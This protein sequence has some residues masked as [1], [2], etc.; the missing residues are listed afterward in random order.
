MNAE[1]R[2]RHQQREQFRMHAY[3]GNSEAFRQSAL[4]VRETDPLKHVTIDNLELNAFLIECDFPA[5]EGKIQSM[6][7]RYALDERF[8]FVN[9]FSDICL[10]QNYFAKGQLRDA[11][12]IANNVI[13]NKAFI[14]D[15]DSA[16][17]LAMYRLLA[18]AYWISGRNSEIDQI[19]NMAGELESNSIHCTYIL[20]AIDA[21]YFCATGEIYKALDMAERN[22]AISSQHSFS[23]IYGPT[24][25]QLVAAEC[26]LH[27]NQNRKAENLLKPV[28]DWSMANNHLAWIVHSRS[29]EVTSLISSKQFKSGLS[30]LREMREILMTLKYKNNLG[31]LADLSEFE[32]R[33]ALEDLD[34]A[35]ILKDRLPKE[36]LGESLVARLG[37]AKGDDLTELLNVLPERNQ[38]DRIEK[39][40]I[41]AALFV[42]RNSLCIEYLQEAINISE[43]TGMRSL[44]FRDEKLASKIIAGANL[45]PTQFLEFLVAEL[46]EYLAKDEVLSSGGI[47]EPLTKR[48]LEVLRSMATGAKIREIGF[49]LHISMNT[50]KTHTRHIY[51]KL[52]ARGRQDAIQIARDHFLI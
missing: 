24:D 50:L 5:V 30:I 29:L 48:E 25:M 8:E 22:I 26:Y 21:I 6:N 2:L 10:S 49:S 4:H 32:L 45:K 47:Y 31:D 28:I 42:D 3:M 37:I 46:T 34:R 15:L 38:K 17:T 16:D 20:N 23:G 19:R 52:G 14:A 33:L 11:I 41:S 12:E 36:I 43:Q 18:Q 1:D 13:G 51:R 39:Q 35:D 44:F 27:L 9:R 7:S 40:L